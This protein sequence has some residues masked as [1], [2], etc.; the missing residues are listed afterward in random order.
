MLLRGP[1]DRYYTEKLHAHTAEEWRQVVEHYIAG[2][3]WVLE[4]YYRGVASW[5]WYY[6]YHYAPMASDLVNLDSIQVQGG[7]VDRGRGR[8]K[9]TGGGW[10]HWSRGGGCGPRSHETLPLTYVVL[11]GVGFPQVAFAQGTPFRPFEQ[12]LAVLPAASCKLLPPAFR[13][14]MTEP[15]SPIIDF[16]PDSF[17]VRSS[18]S[19]FHGLPAVPRMSRTLTELA[20]HLI[21]CPRLTWRAS[22]RTGRA[23]CWCR[24]WTS[25]GCLRR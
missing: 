6:P 20:P 9:A 2:L 3:H 21:R 8:A 13:V 16:Y 14:L 11:V 18:R 1:Q 7:G 4:Y 23:W 25:P 19:S 5:D 22:V 24:S 12:L 10:L 17:D 15:E